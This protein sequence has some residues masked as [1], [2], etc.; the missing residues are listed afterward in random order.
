KMVCEWGMSDAIGPVMVANKQEEVFLGRE[1]AQKSDISEQTA[2]LVDNEI[3]AIL[4]KA[5]NN[6]E[7]LLKD[8]I[9]LLHKV[10]KILLERETIDGEELDM[11]IRGEE[12]PPLTII[13]KLEKFAK[14]L[15][16]NEQSTRTAEAMAPEQ[17]SMN[18]Q[19]RAG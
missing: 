12:L 4:M 18:D 15:P 3:K 2:Q 8:N 11:I 19:E 16:R 10:S 6:A 13:S 14:D 7:Q 5:S 1:I 17:E 9:E